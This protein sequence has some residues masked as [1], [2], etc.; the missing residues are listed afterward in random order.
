MFEEWKK[1][2]SE[3]AFRIIE[4]RKQLYDL[5]ENKLKTPAV[6]PNGWSHITDQIG[7]FSCA[8]PHPLRIDRTDQNCSLEQLHRPQ[9]FVLRSRCS[10]TSTH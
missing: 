2:V 4:M 9:P 6:G 8:I 5:L 10:L 1:D 3:M 7:M